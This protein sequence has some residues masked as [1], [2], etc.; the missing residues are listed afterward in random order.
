MSHSRSLVAILVAICSGPMW[1]CLTLALTSCNAALRERG[2]GRD[3]YVEKETG[4]EHSRRRERGGRCRAQ[5]D[6]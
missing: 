1:M 3:M 5:N 4:R 6:I 2:G